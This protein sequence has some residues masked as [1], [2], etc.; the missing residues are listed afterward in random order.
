MPEFRYRFNMLSNGAIFNYRGV[1]Y[2]KC[3]P[4]VN[5]DFTLYNAVNQRGGFRYFT[6]EYITVKTGL[7]YA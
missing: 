4:I 3:R 7:R 5:L 1:N 6:T 2:V